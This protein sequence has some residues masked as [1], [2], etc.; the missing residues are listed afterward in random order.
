MSD[1]VKRKSEG[2]DYNKGRVRVWLVGKE[3]IGITVN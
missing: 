1:R 2:C 3:R